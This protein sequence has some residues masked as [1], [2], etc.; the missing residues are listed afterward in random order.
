MIA[1]DTVAVIALFLKGFFRTIALG[2]QSEI[3]STLFQTIGQLQKRNCI[4]HHDV[5]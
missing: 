2:K 4:K 1:S 5:N 3:P